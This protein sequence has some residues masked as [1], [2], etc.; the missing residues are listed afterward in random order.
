[1]HPGAFTAHTEETTQ[2]TW[3]TVQLKTSQTVM[4]TCTHVLCRLMYICMYSLALKRTLVCLYLSCR[5]ASPHAHTQMTL[6]SSDF[7]IYFLAEWPWFNFH[8]LNPE[9][10]T[11][12]PPTCFPTIQN[13]RAIKSTTAVLKMQLKSLVITDVHKRVTHLIIFR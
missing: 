2:D 4:H 12:P 7:L 1:M 6:E 5:L 8:V 11:N 9:C 10:A 13:C 3:C